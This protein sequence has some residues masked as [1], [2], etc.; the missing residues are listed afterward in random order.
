MHYFDPLPLIEFQV[1]LKG[2]DTFL[3]LTKGENR[4]GLKQG[5]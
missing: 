1:S 2:D 3:I 4:Y 5:R